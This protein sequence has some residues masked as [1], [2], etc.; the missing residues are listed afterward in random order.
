MT[1]PVVDPAEP[2]F[3]LRPDYYDVLA[4][5]RDDAPLLEVEPGVKLVSRY[6]DIRTVSRDPARFCSGRGV[7]VNDPIR[8]QGDPGTDQNPRKADRKGKGGQG[9]GTQPPLI[10]DQRLQGDEIKKISEIGKHLGDPQATIGAMGEGD[11]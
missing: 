5:L 1:A 2:G 9:A 6:D 10:D 3:F 11:K 7:L 8:Q 4:R